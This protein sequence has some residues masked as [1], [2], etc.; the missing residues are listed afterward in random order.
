MEFEGGVSPLKRK[1]GK[2]GKGRKRTATH[3]GK[4]G[5]KNTSTKRGRAGFSK[6]GPR[7]VNV[8]GYGAL[9]RF[10]PRKLADW[11][12]PLS[13]ATTP[14]TGGGGT[15]SKIG[16]GPGGTT[17]NID[18]SIHDSFNQ[19]QT[20]YGNTGKNNPVVTTDT[21]TETKEFTK[22]KDKQVFRGEGAYYKAWQTNLTDK[23]K[24]EKYGGT[25]LDAF[26]RF[27][28]EA[29]DWN[30]SESGKSWWKEQNENRKKRT[31]TTSKTTKTT[32]STTNSGTG[33]DGDNGDMIMTQNISNF[34]NPN[35]EAALNK[36]DSSPAKYKSH[37]WKM[38]RAVRSKAK[39]PGKVNLKAGDFTYLWA[40]DI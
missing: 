33:G 38:V 31:E 13:K 12:G 10:K 17:I 5:I 2:G 26:K 22:N 24:L 15:T 9:T 34:N 1:R 40:K 6:S 19:T 37:A 16:Q 27:E 30:A 29:R 25:D 7:G 21:T 35:V 28:K 11:S 39:S 8:H 23:Q 20:K 36:R 4:H 3:A 32:T 18:N 14:K